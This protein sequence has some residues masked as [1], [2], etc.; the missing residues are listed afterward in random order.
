MGDES[1]AGYSA[2]LS[3]YSNKGRLNLRSR[4]DP[5]GATLG[6]LTLLASRL[7]TSSHTVIHTG[8][9]LSTA[10]GIADFRGPNGVW[11][12]SRPSS[13][14]TEPSAPSTTFGAAAPTLAHMA[15]LA[16]HRAGIV[17]YV[18][19]QNVDGLHGRSGLPRS[20]LAELHGNLFVEWCQACRREYTRD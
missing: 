15:I 19:S 20:A 11:T 2:R 18:V 4:P 7:R 17:H 12:L 13:T 16:L 9:G 3:P 5:A 1:A 6:K 8:A 10:A 14:H